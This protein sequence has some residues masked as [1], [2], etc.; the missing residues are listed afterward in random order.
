[1]KLMNRLE[2][3]FGD[4]AIPHLT[5]I[6]VGF[7]CFTFVMALTQPEFVLK[8]VLTHDGLFAGQWWRVFTVLVMPP[9]TNPSYLIFILFFVYFFYLMGSALEAQWGTFQYNLYLLI[10]YLATALTVLIPGAI[11]TNTYL[12]TSVFL[13]FA[14][15]FPDFQILLFFILPVKVKWL[16]LV[17]WIMYLV[18]FLVGPWET[19]AEIAAGVVNFGIFFHEDLIQS[20]RGYPR[21]YRGQM[22]RA[23]ARE[24]KPPMHVCAVCGVTEQSDKKMEFRYCPQCKGTPA[25]CINHISNHQHR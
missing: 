24:E 10:G 23:R 9:S 16:G 1:M 3:R 5:L 21:K 6:L 11:V 19:K 22:E 8:L 7:Q 4:F 13:A 2:R 17:A 25:Y 18:M 20:I 14:F 15:L 12:M